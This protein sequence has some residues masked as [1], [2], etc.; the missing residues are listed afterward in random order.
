LTQGY[1]TA[2]PLRT[3]YTY[4]HIGYNLK[5]IGYNLKLIGYNLKLTDRQTAVGVSQLAKVDAFVEARKRNCA[6]LRDKFAD[7]GE[8]FILPH[9][10]QGA[11]PNWFGSCLTVPPSANFTS[12]DLVQ[13]L[14]EAE[15]GTHQLFGGDLMRQPAFLDIEHR[16]VG[17]LSNADLVTAGSFWLGVYPGLTEEMLDHIVTLVRGFVSS[18]RP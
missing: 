18:R 14:E 2:H 13:H 17:D 1:S 10:T 11:D 9:A 16:V 3:R 7:L 8:V 12:H 6:F 15:I 5:H 4:S